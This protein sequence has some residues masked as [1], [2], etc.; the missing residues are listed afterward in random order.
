M[1]PRTKRNAPSRRHQRPP[2]PDFTQP[3]PHDLLA[4]DDDPPQ[5]PPSVFELD[6]PLS[7]P[8]LGRQSD[9]IRSGMDQEGSRH[10]PVDYARDVYGPPTSGSDL[11]D[12]PISIST[13]PPDPSPLR[14]YS[15]AHDAAPSPTSTRSALRKL[16]IAEDTTSDES[17]LSRSVGHIRSPV[18]AR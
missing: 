11:E 1:P 8:D 14:R 5:Q 13:S 18:L 4:F 16:A 9:S 7:D 6:P 15:I 2:Q 12:G 3:E 17:S 10:K